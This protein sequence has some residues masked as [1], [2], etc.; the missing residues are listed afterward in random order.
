M[1]AAGSGKAAWGMD[2]VLV[3]GS[4]GLG[5]LAGYPWI[6]SLDSMPNNVRSHLI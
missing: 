2:R 1:G 5:V 3:T 4:P 6:L